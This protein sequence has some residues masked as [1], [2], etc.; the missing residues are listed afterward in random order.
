MNEPKCPYC[1]SEMT[2]GLEEGFC[3]ILEYLYICNHCGSTS[4]LVLVE[5]DDIDKAK[6][7]ALQKALS[8]VEME[9]EKNL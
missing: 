9:K 7:Q 6:T 5:N 4:P 8:R 3:G 1:G 2:G